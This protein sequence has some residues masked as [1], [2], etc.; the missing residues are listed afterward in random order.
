[1]KYVA[2]YSKEKGWHIEKVIP[3]QPFNRQI[4]LTEEEI[5]DIV[6]KLNSLLCQDSEQYV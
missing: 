4:A 1:M 2:I 3:D 6:I 5:S